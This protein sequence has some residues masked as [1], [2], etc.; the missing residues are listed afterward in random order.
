MIGK[1]MSWPVAALS[2]V[3]LA[4]GAASPAIANQESV[5]LKGEIEAA[6]YDDDGEVASAAVYD[7]EWG[8][9]LIVGQGKGRELLS[10]VGST[11]EITGQLDEI[12]DPDSDY[13]YAIKVA[14]YK[15]VEPAEEPEDYP[16]WDPD[17]D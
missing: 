3:V 15:I 13:S 1:T 16:D 9:V 7:D 10:H 4:I 2:A 6:D 12:D 14:S 17:D 11:A 5:T 8:W